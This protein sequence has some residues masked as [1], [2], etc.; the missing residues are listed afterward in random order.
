MYPHRR[1]A[2][3]RDLAKELANAT[4]I[5]VEGRSVL[6]S[7]SRLII[8]S[9]LE[10]MPLVRTVLQDISR[11]ESDLE[12]ELTALGSA[13]DKLR[14]LSRPIWYYYH[15]GFKEVRFTA[16]VAWREPSKAPHEEAVLHLVKSLMAFN[17]AFIAMLTL[18]EA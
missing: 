4:F 11:I 13:L 1:A 12:A 7:G 6:E 15:R 9:F 2:E 18:L 3:V 17:N 16:T 8:D 5:G 14:E 10:S